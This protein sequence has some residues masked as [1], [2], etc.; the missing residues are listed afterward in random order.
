MMFDRKSEEVKIREKHPLGS[1]S[2]EKEDLRVKLSM[3]EWSTNEKKI[4]RLLIGHGVCCVSKSELVE[5]RS[6]MEIAI[7]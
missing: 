1:N 3:Y 2:S 4:S 5:P 6:V 7:E